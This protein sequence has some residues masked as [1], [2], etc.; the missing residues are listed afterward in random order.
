MD[1]D[2]SMKASPYLTASNVS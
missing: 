2:Q 1:F